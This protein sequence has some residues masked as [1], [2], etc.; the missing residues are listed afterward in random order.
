[1]PFPY[2][3]PFSFDAPT[4]S[5]SATM[6]ISVAMTASATKTSYATATMAISVAMTASFKSLLLETQRKS[7]YRGLVRVVLTKTGEDTLTYY[8]TDRV[9]VVSHVE[10]DDSYT[11]QV[12]LSNHDNIFTDLDLRGYTATI[13]WGATTE[14]G[15]LYSIKAPLSVFYQQFNSVPGQ[16]YCIL[17]CISIID[18]I[19]QQTA[20]G[21]YLPV[22][23]VLDTLKTTIN[24]LLA[25][26]GSYGFAA[27]GAIATQWDSHDSLIDTFKLKDY[28]KVY[29]GESRLARVNYCLG[30]SKE[31]KRLEADGKLHFLNP[32]ISGTVYDYEY[33]LA[34]THSF[35]SKAYSKT[36]MVPNNFSLSGNG[37]IGS[38][39]DAAS[40]AFLPKFQYYTLPLTS[41]AEGDAIAAAML[42]RATLSSQRGSIVVPMNVFQQVWDYIK[43]TDSREDGSVRTGNVQYIRR[44]CEAS[45]DKFQMEFRLGNSSGTIPDASIGAGISSLKESGGNVTLSYLLSVLAPI[46]DSI[47]ELGD[48]GLA[49]DARLDTIETTLADIPQAHEANPSG[50]TVIDTQARA[51]INAIL[52]KLEALGFFSST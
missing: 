23:T 45:S 26:T 44:T 29:E 27:Y 47:L 34:G 51:T 32:T 10:Q 9:V 6:A 16:L 13:S 38:A 39:V 28:F 5:A 19:A 8:N 1:M 11:A 33:E 31:V 4:P 52:A 37:Y 42:Q 48:I 3:F 21:D 25:G 22:A 30:H 43:V 2:T 17:T 7:S 50:G 36:Y 40:F 20:I 14:E 41:N 12:V 46:Y 35:F 49:L 15:D 18:K 24:G